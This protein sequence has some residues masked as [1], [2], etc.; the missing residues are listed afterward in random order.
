MSLLLQVLG[1]V[2]L[3]ELGDK[4]QFLMIAMSSKYKIRDI[5]IGS[6][7]AICTLN[8]LA[9]LVGTILGGVLPTA[10]IGLVAGAAFLIFAYM[11][12]ENG[13]E[14]DAEISGRG[15]RDSVFTVF[16]TFFLAELG[17]KT[18]LT[19]LTLAID[20]SASGIDAKRLWIIF[21]GASMALLAADVL[22]LLVGYFLGRTIPSG[23][24]SWISFGIFSVFGAVR[25]IEGFEQA[26]A[27]C[28]RERAL[29]IIFT[30]AL[31]AI[32]VLAT[33]LKLRQSSTGKRYKVRCENGR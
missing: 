28:G 31:C 1:M 30:S 11:A 32:L 6:A 14:E 4:S 26:F 23:V 12:V 13:E 8:I 3:A 24:F 10:T 16:G 20:S 25:L 7:A 21:I 9:I 22:G 2:F 27:F 29:S 15:S 5:I 17:D 18:Q 33:L 19:A